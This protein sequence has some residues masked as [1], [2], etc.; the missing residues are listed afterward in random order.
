MNLAM[1][2]LTMERSFAEKHYADPVTNSFFGGCVEYIVS[3]PILAMVWEG[4][5][6]LPLG[7]TL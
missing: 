1:K 5:M 4:K 7:N 3:G 6:L 2:F